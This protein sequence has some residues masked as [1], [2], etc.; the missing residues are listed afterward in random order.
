[1][2]DNYI[3][4]KVILLFA[5]SCLFLWAASIITTKRTIK[6]IG[7]NRK[8]YPKGYIMPGRKFR[9]IFGLKKTEIPKWCYRT[10]L[11]SFLVVIYFIIGSLIYLF[12]T[13]KIFALDL[14]EHGYIVMMTF[15]LI[16]F[17]FF[18]KLY[19]K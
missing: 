9:K 7:I 15:Y 19:K 16:H 11:F 13:D 6:R 12:A 10:F 5:A 18:S 2:V 17:S 14:F 3:N 4:E 1:M 8:Y